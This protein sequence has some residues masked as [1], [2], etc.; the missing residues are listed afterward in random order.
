VIIGDMFDD[1]I[2]AEVPLAQGLVGLTTV[3]LVH[4]L[5][6]VATWKNQRLHDLLC[7]TPRP[8]IR[9][10]KYLDKALAQERTPSGEVEMQLRLLGE[11][12]L[13]EIKEACWE[14]SGELSVEK[15]QPAKPA[16][17]RDRPALLEAA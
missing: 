10:G 9:Q 13:E 12:K 14:P 5:T 2:W 1:I 8:V 3:V 7:S 4:S 6:S 15:K 16:Q 11:D 17:K